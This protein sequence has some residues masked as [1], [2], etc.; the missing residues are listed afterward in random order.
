ME[1]G[2]GMKVREKQEG[3]GGVGGR[4]ERGGSKGG[5]TQPTSPPHN[6]C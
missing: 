2:T 1:G 5:E 6:P 4:E 3:R